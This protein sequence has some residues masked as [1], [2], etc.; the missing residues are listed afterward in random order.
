[1]RR[2]VAMGSASG[3]GAF[4]GVEDA[5]T[6][7]GA[8]ADVEE[9]A[10]RREARSNEVDGARDVGQD[11]GDGLWYALV[12]LVDEAHELERRYF[13]DMERARIALLRRELAEIHG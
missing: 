10:A 5:E 7:R 8:R 2:A 6:S 11:G 3:S 13:V 9:P 4:D 1:M 12:F